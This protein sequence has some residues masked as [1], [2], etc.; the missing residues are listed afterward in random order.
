M[1]HLSY[2]F[3]FAAS[4]ALCRPWPVSSCT[5]TPFTPFSRASGALTAYTGTHTLVPS[6]VLWSARLGQ[7]PTDHQMAPS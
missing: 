2:A 1:N 3:L 4:L 5:F 6:H 7:C